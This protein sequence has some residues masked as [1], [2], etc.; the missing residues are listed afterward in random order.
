VREVFTFLAEETQLSE[1]TKYT[2]RKHLE[3]I[4]RTVL[5]TTGKILG[6]CPVEKF[7]QKHVQHV[8]DVKRAKPEASNG[9]ERR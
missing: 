4:C 2:R 7:A 9:R 6:D 8:L 3:D 5:P 1:G